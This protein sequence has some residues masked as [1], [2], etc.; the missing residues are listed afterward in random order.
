MSARRRASV[1]TSDAA[2]SSPGD[3]AA[4]PVMDGRRDDGLDVDADADAD[5]T[6]PLAS[7]GLSSRRP[8]S[9]AISTSRLPCEPSSSAPPEPCCAPAG[10]DRASSLRKSVRELPPPVDAAARRLTTARTATS[11][12]CSDVAYG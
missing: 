11:A 12:S 5:V 9:S 4:A 1:S 3:P 7:S 6:E 10:G 8:D 2:A